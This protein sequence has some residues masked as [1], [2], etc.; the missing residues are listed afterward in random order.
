MAIAD[1]DVERVRMAQPIS[2][3]IGN[4]VALKRAGRNFLGLCPLWSL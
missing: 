3:V 1:D 2:A 4:Y